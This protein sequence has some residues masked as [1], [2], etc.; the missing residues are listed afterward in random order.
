MTLIVRTEPQISPE[1]RAAKTP[2]ACRP[3][4]PKGQSSD[5]EST[6][7]QRG[8]VVVQAVPR[9]LIDK[10]RER[11]AT[12][13]LRNGILF[14]VSR[15]LPLFPPGARGHQAPQHYV[16]QAAKILLQ[17]QQKKSGLNS[18]KS[19]TKPR[20][21]QSESSRNIY[22]LTGIAKV[23]NYPEVSMTTMSPQQMQQLLSPGQLQAL[24]QQQQH[25]ILL[26][27][28]SRQQLVFQQLLQQELFKVQRPGLASHTLFPAGLSTIE[29]QQI[30]KELTNSTM[31]EKSTKDS[32]PDRVITTTST[33]SPTEPVTTAKAS[34]THN[35]PTNGQ[36]LSSSPRE[37]LLN[38]DQTITHSLYGYGVCIWPGCETVCENASQFIKH[39]S[40]EHMLD[41]RSTDQCRVQMQVVQQLDL[42]LSKERER[43][44]AM[45]AHLHLPP[46]EPQ[47]SSKPLSSGSGVTMSKSLPPLSPQ[48]DPQ[49]SPTAPVTSPSSPRGPAGL[50]PTSV[51]AMRRH[52]SDKHPSL[53]SLSSEFSPNHEMYRNADIRPPFT[54]A[55]LIRQAIMDASDMQ[56]TLNEIY[57]WFTRTFA[58]FRRNAA[59]WKNAVRHNLSLHKCFVRV[60]N[61]KG[62]VWTV[63]EV[64]YQRR[65]SQKI[66]R[67]PTLGKNLLSSLAY[68]TALNTSLQAP[69]TENALTVL[70][71][72][73]PAGLTGSSHLGLV[74]LKHPDLQDTIGQRSPHSTSLAQLP[75]VVKE[76]ET[77]PVIKNLEDKECLLQLLTT[78][79]PSS[80]MQQD[81]EQKEGHQ[82]DL[83]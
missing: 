51:G 78:A 75:L 62:A 80:E 52:H 37:G 36:S 60:E 59:T 32:C 70:K 58:Y 73:S 15:L 68:W 12:V 28:L 25:A 66:T 27:Q 47:S 76:E 74:H 6:A 19:H 4:Q 22:W 79:N 2:A 31:E 40:I 34:N 43:L 16:L 45:M 21:L 30:W 24:L 48:D 14:Q 56:L 71:N 49:M 46:L 81:M 39:L 82:S 65:R 50:C 67:S 42:Q 10:D 35:F 57:R 7:Q 83:E 63:D 72:K 54:Y 20:P 17:Q 77:P 69:L 3:Q 64:E 41:E 1:E 8:A 44:Q 53:C 23:I 29:L 9:Q 13:T 55:T 33:P 26:Q 61:V 18:A 5:P 38:V 11:C